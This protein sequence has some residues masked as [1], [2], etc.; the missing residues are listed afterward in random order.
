LRLLAADRVHTGPGQTVV[1]PEDV[2]PAL[3]RA[4]DER[5][6]AVIEVVTE[7]RYPRSEGLSAGYSDFPV[8]T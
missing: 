3:K 8:P 7:S 1:H 6:P 4:F 2:G 5:R